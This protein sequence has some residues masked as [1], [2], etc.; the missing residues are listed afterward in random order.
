MSS[1]SDLRAFRFDNIKIDRSFVADMPVRDDCAAIVTA[2]AGL[3]RNLGADT[4][5]EGVET[6]EQAA[7]VRAA[8]C[9]LA[10]GY[11]YARPVSAAAIR[12]LL[13]SAEIEAAVA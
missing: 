10:Q 9:T 5:A 8:G 11:L 1:L 2:I 13:E 3:G 6:P 7:F 4:T 12:A